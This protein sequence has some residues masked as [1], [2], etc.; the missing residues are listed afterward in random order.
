M[1]G[2]VL[3]KA[4]RLVR[5]PYYY[6]WRFFSRVDAEDTYIVAFQ[7]SG[8]TWLRCLI[9]SYARDAVATPEVVDE[10][11]P[12]VT[13][14]RQRGKVD[15]RAFDHVGVFKS[16]AEYVEI[17]ARVIY[18]VRDGRDA[19]LSLYYYL[20]RRHPDATEPGE[21]FFTRSAFGTWHEHVTGWLDG[22]ERWPDDR[23]I[24]VRYEDMLADPERYLTDIVRF[25]GWDVD[26]DRIARAVA[27]NTKERMRALDESRPGALEF[28]ASTN[29]TWD[30]VLSRE[31][32]ARYEEL[33]GAALVR[34]GYPLSTR[35]G[36]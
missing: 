18:L 20:Q 15:K 3:R 1:V 9:A 27:R 12:D 34:A 30:G 6:D 17:P 8:T 28:P 33:V 19:M 14:S 36:T 23:S 22:L 25:L 10:A 29:A 26:P 7:R 2:R 32:I 24:V 4:T 21:F 11:V 35:A 16:H 31:E 5:G 13:L